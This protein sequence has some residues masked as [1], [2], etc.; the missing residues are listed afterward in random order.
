MHKSIQIN[1]D[2]NFEDN[3]QDRLHYSTA[4]KRHSHYYLTK[5]C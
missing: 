3:Q 5:K 2:T 4:T 1:N